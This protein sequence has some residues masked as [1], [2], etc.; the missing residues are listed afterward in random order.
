MTRTVNRGFAV[1]MYWRQSNVGLWHCYER[2]PGTRDYP[3]PR[4]ESLCGRSMLTKVGGQQRSRPPV[5][6]RCG[7]CDSRE[8]HAMGAN[9]SLPASKQRS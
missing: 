1:K 8:I 7:L 2:E 6:Q 3:Q 9:E 5:E 4:F